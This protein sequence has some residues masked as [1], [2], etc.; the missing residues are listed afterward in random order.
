M[1][2]ILFTIQTLNKLRSEQTSVLEEDTKECYI[3]NMQHEPPTN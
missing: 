3:Q 1:K 2:Y